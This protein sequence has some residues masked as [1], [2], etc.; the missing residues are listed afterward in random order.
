MVY[1]V[2]HNTA[3]IEEHNIN[4]KN[5]K[6]IVHRKGATRAFG[7]GR[8]EIPQKYRSI[9]STSNHRWKYGNRFVS[10]IRN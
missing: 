5:K 9:G 1:D 7:P 2:A 3:K 8:D 4:G 6:V 10:I